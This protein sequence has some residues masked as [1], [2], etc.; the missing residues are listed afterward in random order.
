MCEVMCDSATRN[1]L[2]I[3]LTF[4]E[5]QEAIKAFEKLAVEQYL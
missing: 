4:Q 1:K 5:Q 2:P 3:R